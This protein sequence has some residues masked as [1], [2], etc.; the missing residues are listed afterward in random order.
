MMKPSLSGEQ[1]VSLHSSYQYAADRRYAEGEKRGALREDGAEH[2][3][4]RL[5]ALSPIIEDGRQ[6]LSV[7]VSVSPSM[8]QGGVSS[9]GCPHVA[10]DGVGTGLQRGVTAGDFEELHRLEADEKLVG[11]ADDCSSV[12]G[13]DI[14]GSGIGGA[15]GCGDGEVGQGSACGWQSRS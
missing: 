2:A 6:V 4:I 8:L 9:E 5:D 15:G 10:G 3:Q 11:I 13:N 14:V 12:C 1:L 7:C